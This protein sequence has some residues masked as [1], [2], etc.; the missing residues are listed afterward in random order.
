MEKLQDHLEVEKDRMSQC[1]LDLMNVESFHETQYNKDTHVDLAMDMWITHNKTK[2][3]Y[4]TKHFSYHPSTTPMPRYDKFKCLL[5]YY[6]YTNETCWY[7][8]KNN[9]AE[10]GYSGALGKKKL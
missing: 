2:V 5:S 1:K 10:A 7:D 4:S 3:A 9:Y 8:T 6:G